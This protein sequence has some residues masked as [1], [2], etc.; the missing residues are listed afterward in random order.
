MQRK[1]KHTFSNIYK[2]L[3]SFR[4]IKLKV[5]ILTTLML[6]IKKIYF[7]N[8]FC[9]KQI[10]NY[11]IFD[12][13]SQLL[14]KKTNFSNKI[15][16]ENAFYYKNIDIIKHKKKNKNT[17]ISNIYL[18]IKNNKQNKLQYINISHN[19]Y[20]IFY[21]KI[22][23]KKLINFTNISYEKFFSQQNNHQNKKYK[24]T[25]IKKK[26]TSYNFFL[27]KQLNKNFIYTAKLA[28]INNID[29]YNVIQILKKK[30]NFRKLN[31]EDHCLL[32]IKKTTYNDKYKN[33]LI[34][35]RIR[36][37]GKN[38]Y[39][40]RNQ[41]GKLCYHNIL[42]INNKTFLRFP[43]KKNFRIS[44]NFNLN[45]IHPITGKIS[46]HNGI[47]L[48][49]PVGTPVLSVGDGIVKVSKKSKIAGNYISIYHNNKHTTKYMHL[50][51]SLVKEGQKVQCGE[52]IGLSGNTGRSTGPHLHFEVWI[53]K[54]AV[55][56]LTIDLTHIK[57][58]YKNK[59][60]NI[61]SETEWILQQLQLY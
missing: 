12:K 53:N 56:P 23:K 34:G 57:S 52:C 3:F 59:Q 58:L 46:P 33:K 31:K 60:K 40:F 45:R 9:I 19:V 4:E 15:Y 28:G 30:I 44:S 29:I 37:K 39:I 38:Y 8:S 32:L 51:N 11:V 36:T 50:K 21:K 6:F 20:L 61:F 1:I 16:Y 25:N 13:H 27:K 48:A 17:I 54:K 42:Q 26:K 14:Q 43:I 22:H 49:V 2:Y 35:I 5:L 41:Q 55:N 18:E 7:N 24:Q 47:D 10:N